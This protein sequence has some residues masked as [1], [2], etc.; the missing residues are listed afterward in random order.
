MTTKSFSHIYATR[1]TSC[2]RQE[3]SIA[4]IQP[5]LTVHDNGAVRMINIAK[6]G[7]WGNNVNDVKETKFSSL[8]GEDYGVKV[9]S[10]V[11]EI[12]KVLM[13]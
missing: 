13:T 5:G 8:D 4:T 9:L 11:V 6:K 7:A 2:I 3:Y 10:E 1:A 12:S